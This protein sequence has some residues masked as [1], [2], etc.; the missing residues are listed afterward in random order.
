MLKIEV[1]SM[2]SNTLIQALGSG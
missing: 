1:R 2:T